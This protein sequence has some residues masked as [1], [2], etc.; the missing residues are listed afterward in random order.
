M[1]FVVEV[2]DFYLDSESGGVEEELKKYVTNSVIVQIE[3]NMNKKIDEEI[4]RV[5]TSHVQNIL[6]KKISAKVAE[7]IELGEILDPDE[8]CRLGGGGKK[9]SISSFITKQFEKNRGWNSP[10]E[11][12]SKIAAKWG[13]EIKNRYDKAFAVHIVETM[14]KNGLLKDDAIAKLLECA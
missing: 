11:Q 9:I 7:L 13:D 14:K 1:K 4:T 6:L 3:K 8:M 5:V 2:E 12:I 10:Y